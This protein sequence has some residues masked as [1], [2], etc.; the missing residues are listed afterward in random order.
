MFKLNVN[1]TEGIVFYDDMDWIQLDPGEYEFLCYNV[2]DASDVTFISTKDEHVKYV[3]ILTGLQDPDGQPYKP[4]ETEMCLVNFKYPE[5]TE[6]D[7]FF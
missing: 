5:E 7:T 4:D 3:E 1:L 6:G 2:N